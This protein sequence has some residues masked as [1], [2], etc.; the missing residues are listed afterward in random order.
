LLGGERPDCATTT[1][2]GVVVGSPALAWVAAAIEIE[3]ATAAIN[4]DAVVMG[5]KSTRHLNG[6]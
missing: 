1:G 3:T 6:A 5:K 4:F 2:V